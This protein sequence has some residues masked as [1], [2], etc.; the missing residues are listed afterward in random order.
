MLFY[1]P[2]KLSP[3]GIYIVPERKLLFFLPLQAGRQAQIIILEIPQCIPVVIIF[4]F[5]DLGKNS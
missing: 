1:Q 2:V 4:A 5:L 3:F